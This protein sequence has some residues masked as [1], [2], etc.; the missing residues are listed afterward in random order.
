MKKKS[1]KERFWE[2]VKVESTGCWTWIGRKDHRGYGRFCTGGRDMPAHR[3][4]YELAK[5][6][7]DPDKEL[8]HICRHRACVRP[9]HLKALSHGENM[10]LAA[11]A[12]VWNGERNGNCKRKEEEV[13]AI[14]ALCK[15]V[16]IPAR[17]LSKIMNIPLRSVFAITRGECWKHLEVPID[18]MIKSTRGTE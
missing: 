12:G 9:S 7:L 8:H 18:L 17:Y 4:S 3:Y 16:P 11:Q 1:A 13:L 15:V 10:R 6:K 14:K 2:K 5:G